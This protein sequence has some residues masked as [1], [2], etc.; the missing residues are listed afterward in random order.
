MTTF[1]HSTL[2]LTVSLN[3][4]TRD[5]VSL[6]GDVYSIPIDAEG[7]EGLV[8]MTA[9]INKQSDADARQIAHKLQ[10]GKTASGD[11]YEGTGTQRWLIQKSRTT[12]TAT[13][14]IVLVTMKAKEQDMVSC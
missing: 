11:Y 5:G 9:I 12:T 6:T 7:P 8:K 14:S 10:R 4:F 1:T 13:A 3:F 2:P